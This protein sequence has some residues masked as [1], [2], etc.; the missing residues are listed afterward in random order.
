MSNPFA[1]IAT[2][3]GRTVAQAKPMLARLNNADTSVRPSEKKWAKK[4][5]LGHLA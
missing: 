2:D 5:I 3:L 4:E 1:E